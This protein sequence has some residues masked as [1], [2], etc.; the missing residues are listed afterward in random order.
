[1]DTSD[2][3][4]KMLVGEIV[5][6]WDRLELPPVTDWDLFEILVEAA[7]LGR[8]DER[9][10]RAGTVALLAARSKLAQA[11]NAQVA[12]NLLHSIDTML[13]RGPD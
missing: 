13:G 1:M 6:Q 8:S 10:R 7:R 9:A 5:S 4:L 12:G 2:Q 3:A 11:G